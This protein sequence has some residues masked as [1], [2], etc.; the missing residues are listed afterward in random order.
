MIISQPQPPKPPPEPLK[1]PPPPPHAITHAELCTLA[2]A[3]KPVVTLP[4]RLNE[5][6]FSVNRDKEGQITSY[7][8]HGKAVP[9]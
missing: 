4:P 3:L 6:V 2:T 5:W 9:S 1:L 8:G 7:H